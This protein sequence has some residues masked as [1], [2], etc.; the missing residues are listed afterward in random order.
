MLLENVFAS[1]TCLVMKRDNLCL[2]F[3]RN[4]LAHLSFVIVG[5]IIFTMRDGKQLFFAQKHLKTPGTMTRSNMIFVTV[6]P[7]A[8]Q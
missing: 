1:E 4:F 2:K 3:K 7:T 6:S 5:D 8:V